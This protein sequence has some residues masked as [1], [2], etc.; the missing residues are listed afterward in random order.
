MTQLA[1]RTS[2]SSSMP[3]FPMAGTASTSGPVAAP[4][5][6]IEFELITSFEAFEALESEWNELHAE[7]GRSP[8]IFQA[9]NWCW[10]WCRHYLGNG[11][12]GAALAIVTG[13]IDGRLALI[14]PLVTHHKAGLIELTWLGE[15]VSQYSDV[16]ARPEAATVE[17]LQ[18]AWQ[19]AVSQTGADV[20]NLRRVRDDATAAPLLAHIGADVTA[21]EEAPFLT[22][23]GDTSYEGW[24][25]R[26]QPRARKNRRRQAKRLAEQGEIT[27]LALSDSKE[28]AALAQ[29][30]VRLKRDTLTA[31]GAISPT[32]SDTRFEQFF[33]DAA[34]GLG[35]PTGITVM[36]LASAGTPAALK[37]LIETPDTAFL[38][39]A[40]FEPSYEKCG[41]G[42]LLLEHVVDRSIKAHRRELD[43]L[44]PRHAY[45]LDFADGIMLVRD[46]A[47]ALSAKGWLYKKAYLGLRHQLKAVVEALPLPIR[48]FIA[49]LVGEHRHAPDEGAEHHSAA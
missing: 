31:K 45:K 30:A 14:M 40:V 28:A 11:K 25:T 42:A 46:Y 20:A 38:H 21:T 12:T 24:E 43:L 22:L 34:N 32:L 6:R 13:R 44:P 19:F 23:A 41:V 49:R 37:I 1:L 47:I 8:Q 36:A 10:H 7:I 26:R 18:A 39:V 4:A 35:R 9:F 33:A 15:P 29:H 16:L 27:F 48:R 2:Q 3:A 5:T 17:S